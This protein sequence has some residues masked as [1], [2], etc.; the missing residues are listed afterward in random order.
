MPPARDMPRVRYDSTPRVCATPMRPR[1]REHAPMRPRARMHEIIAHAKTRVDRAVDRRRARERA[2]CTM[3]IT[4][5]I[6]PI[7]STAPRDI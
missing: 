5:P 1:A 2:G 7:A 4:N 3:R 6:G